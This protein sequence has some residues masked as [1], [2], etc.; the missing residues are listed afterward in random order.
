MLVR[1]CVA[2][3]VARR[4]T[5]VA[6][7]LIPWPYSLSMYLTVFPCIFSSGPCALGKGILV[8]VFTGTGLHNSAYELVVVFYTGL[9]LLQ[10]EVSLMR[11]TIPP[12]P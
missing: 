9:C 10:R 5:R 1:F 12:M 3:D 11:E 8:G 2:S 4:L 6:N 7:F